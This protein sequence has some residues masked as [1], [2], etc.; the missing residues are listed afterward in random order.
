MRYSKLSLLIPCALLLSACT[1]V[2]PAYKDNG[3]RIG[4]CVEGGPDSV[5]Q[6]FYDYRIQHHS[7]DIAALRPYLS[8][9]LAKLLT[10]ASRATLPDSANV[11]S[12]STIPNRDARNIPLRVALKQ[13]DQ[14]WQ[15]EVLMIHE[16]SCWVI[17]DVRYLGGDV[18]APA[19]TL[20]QSIENR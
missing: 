8:D 17:D 1:T 16:G 5:A 3:P 20:R 10:D 18:H 2:T 15:D 19:G 13:G 6:Q 4:A 11:A 7:N 12:A 14:S 9:N